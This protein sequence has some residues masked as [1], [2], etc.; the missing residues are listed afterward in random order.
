MNPS[1]TLTNVKA[2]LYEILK[3]IILF[4]GVI[5]FGIVIWYIV[6]ISKGF[7]HSDCTDTIFWAGAMIEGKTIMNPD[8]AMPVFC[9]LVETY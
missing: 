1:N 5:T 7:Y 9:H 8:L 2:M 3:Y 4:S 6:C